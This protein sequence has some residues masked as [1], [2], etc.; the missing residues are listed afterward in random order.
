MTPRQRSGRTRS[1]QAKRRYESNPKFCPKCDEPL[2]FTKRWN[3]FCGSSC[4]ASFNNNRKGTGSTGV[5]ADC[6]K[7]TSN[8]SG[9]PNKFCD[10][11]ISLGKHI[12]RTQRSKDANC[13]KALRSYLLRTRPHQ[14]EGCRGK[15][16]LGL[17][18]PLEVDHQDGDATNNEEENLRLL[19]PNCHAL[20]PTSKGKN[21]GRGRSKRR[22]RRAT[23]AQSV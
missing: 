14:C 2:P 15:T 22:K 23:I 21:R 12:R 13:E 5:C 7:E 9:T 20:C 10:L 3:K 18:I 6:G 4:A 8:R 1:T 17:P 16:W 11:C 19:C